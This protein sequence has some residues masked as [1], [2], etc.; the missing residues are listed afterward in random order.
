MVDEEK[1][2][3]RAGAEMS[4][5]SSKRSIEEANKEENKELIEQ[6]RAKAR[7]R[8]ADKKAK[9]GVSISP[10]AKASP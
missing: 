4:S 7:Q 5:A 3:A 6:S 9:V 1:K 8:L 2:N 10:G